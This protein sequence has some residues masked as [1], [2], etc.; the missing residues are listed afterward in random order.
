[1]QSLVHQAI[2]D[3]S[4]SLNYCLMLLP[5]VM[6][7]LPAVLSHFPVLL[8]CSPAFCT[9]VESSHPVPLCL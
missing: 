8:S 6:L 2:P 4:L 5:E 7:T 9:S 1:M 3:L